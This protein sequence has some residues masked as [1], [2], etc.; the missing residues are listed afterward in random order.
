MN[1][2]LLKTATPEFIR[3]H[4]AFRKQNAEKYNALHWDVQYTDIPGLKFGADL[5]AG[6]FCLSHDDLHTG[7]NPLVF[8]FR[9]C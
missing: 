6:F 1:K 7:E 2:E 5:G 8:S 9:N 3:E 4:L